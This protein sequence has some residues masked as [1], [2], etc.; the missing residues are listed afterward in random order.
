MIIRLVQ[1]VFSVLCKRLEQFYVVF[2][3]RIEHDEFEGIKM[4]L[5]SE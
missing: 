2:K 3:F 5:I 4:S 1:D